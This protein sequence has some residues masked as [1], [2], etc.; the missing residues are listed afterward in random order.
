MIGDELGFLA[1]NH[2]IHYAEPS[3]SKNG[4]EKLILL[5]VMG[6]VQN[7]SGSGW[8]LPLAF[9]FGF[10]RVSITNKVRVWSG[11]GLMPRST[12]G[13]GFILFGFSGFWVFKNSYIFTTINSK[14]IFWSIGYKWSIKLEDFGNF[15]PFLAF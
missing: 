10:V 15:W 6:R 5:L 11:S 8:S 14:S 9:G 2:Q 13:F 3:T 12:F 4:I 7:S 1:L